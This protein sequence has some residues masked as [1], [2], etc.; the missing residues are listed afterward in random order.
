MRR[1][2]IWTVSPLDQPKARPAVVVSVDAW[3]VHAPDVIL[4]PLTSKPGPSRPPVEHAALR[5]TSYAKCG[6]VSA[7][8]KGRLG[9]RIGEL[10]ENAMAGIERE[11]R[12]LLG[13]GR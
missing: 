3:N 5:T 2:E 13:V 9:K 8:A 1:G 7:V 10:H 6:S 12:R 11:L 4:V